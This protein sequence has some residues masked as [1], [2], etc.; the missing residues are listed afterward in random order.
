[1]GRTWRDRASFVVRAPSA[2][3]E[4]AFT[5]R[6]LAVL[7]LLIAGYI[8]TLGW[9]RPPMSS[10]LRGFQI[11]L[12]PWKTVSLD[13]SKLLLPG[14][15]VRW[16]SIGLVILAFIA[17][18]LVFVWRR[19][20]RLPI[21]GG[22][23]LAAAI[24][25]NA[26]TAFN[27][28]TLVEAL[29]REYQQRRQYVESIDL[30]FHEE[31]PMSLMDNARITELGALQADEQR[32]DLSRGL[33]YLRQGW[34]LAAW[35]GLGILLDARRSLAWRLRA[36]GIAS[37][38]GCVAAVL[39]CSQRLAAEYRWEEA[40]I[41]ERQGH[42][43]EARRTINDVV[44]L[45]PEM[46]RLERTALLAGKIDNRLGKKT[47]EERFFRAFQYGRDR[48]RPRGVAYATD[49][50][51]LIPGVRDWRMQLDAPPVGLDCRFPAGEIQV[52]TPRTQR[53]AFEPVATRA[54]TGGLGQGRDSELLWALTLA[55]ENV[56][57]GEL[58]SAANYQAADLWT[59]YGIAV[60]SRG[61]MHKTAEVVGFEE[62]Q[63]LTSA[64]DAWKR[65]LR[66]APRNRAANFYCG[67][68]QA[69]L[70]RTN[71]DT[72]ARIMEPILE[73]THDLP[74]HADVRSILG[75]AYFQAG[76]FSQA[77]RFFVE[78]F[79]LFNLPDVNQINYRAQRRLGGL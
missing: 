75:D 19:S 68:A 74:M 52:G 62:S 77:R 55:D 26:A 17:L 66:L 31:D 40:K 34:W 63:G 28:P 41:L 4:A 50:P 24:A 29:D 46:G 44:A 30:S 64:I 42:F 61:L 48:S 7:F 20:S 59:I 39:F 22:V 36:L 72:A 57:R 1:M 27:H 23:L 51:W 71:P 45:F 8:A 70:D 18:A 14:R 38:L 58:G 67:I 69:R 76:R 13:E 10:D 16:D 9:I 78:S 6:G 56:A 5:E 79:D 15:P 35:A 49:L 54:D 11:P 21:A 43:A 37:A 2:L 25:G 33:V 60:H 3:L 32:G 47:P 12:G 53:E 65:G 73:E